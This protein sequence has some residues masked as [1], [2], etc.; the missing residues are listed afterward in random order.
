MMRDVGPA[1][2]LLVVWLYAIA[3]LQV[4][5]IRTAKFDP[6]DFKKTLLFTYKISMWIGVFA[7]PIGLI[8]WLVQQ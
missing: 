4:P 3:M 2:L 5:A 7:V 1:V 6:S 8:S